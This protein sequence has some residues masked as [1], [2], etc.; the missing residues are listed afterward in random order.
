MPFQFGISVRRGVHAMTQRSS[1]L[2]R[3]R[4]LLGNRQ[5][6]LFTTVAG[7]GS[8][9]SRPMAL[10]E[11]D[12]DGRLWFITRDGSGK[13]RES[14]FNHHVNAGFGPEGD[15]TWISVSGLATVLYDPAHIARLWSPALQVY[16]PDGPADPSLCLIR[17]E[18]GR[19]EY[20]RGPDGLV[21]KALYFA[22]AAVTGDPHVL[23][24]NA[25]MDLR[26]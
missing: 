9:V 26:H 21:G 3:L 6:A 14:R 15:E 11:V 23:S 18:P 12:E 8:L 1:D 17:L 7:D 25:R 10:R 20:W 5:T 19:V 2:L 22:M 13:T 16:F 24:E 4:E